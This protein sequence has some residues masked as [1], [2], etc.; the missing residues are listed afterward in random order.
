MKFMNFV[1]GVTNHML[2]SA[3]P[4]SEIVLTFNVPYLLSM[5][6]DY[7]GIPVVFYGFF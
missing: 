6:F 3:G 4:T 7:N 5:N 1:I 2:V